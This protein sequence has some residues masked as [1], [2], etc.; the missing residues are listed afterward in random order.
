MSKNWV[1]TTTATCA[2]EKDEG[3]V[4]KEGDLSELGRRRLLSS[5]CWRFLVFRAIECVSNAKVQNHFLVLSILLMRH[6]YERAWS[7]W[8]L[9]SC[10][11]G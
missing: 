3:E 7:Y 8:C 5:S 1:S 2:G 9:E 6:C 11:D 10:V 4:G